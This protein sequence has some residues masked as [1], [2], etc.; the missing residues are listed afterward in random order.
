[1]RKKKW[2]IGW[3]Y[4][5]KKASKVQIQFQDSEG[6]WQIQSQY[7]VID[8]FTIS[9]YLLDEIDEMVNIGYVQTYSVELKKEE[10]L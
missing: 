1:M 8:D 4:E 9:I 5:G 10:L 3:Y 6:E 2:R 7:D